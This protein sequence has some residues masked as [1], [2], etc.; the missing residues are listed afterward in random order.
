M[1]R[2]P[3]SPQTALHVRK[4]AGYREQGAFWTALTVFR[5]GRWE[6][7]RHHPDKFCRFDQWP[8]S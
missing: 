7:Y 2:V 8:V 1:R 6:K 3:N 5:N 4:V